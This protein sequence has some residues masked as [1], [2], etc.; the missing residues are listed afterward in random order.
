MAWAMT[1][2]APPGIAAS[3]RS[4]RTRSARASAHGQWQ[5]EPEGRAALGTRLG[6]DAPAVG[7]DDAPADRQPDAAALVAILAVQAVERPEDPLCL[8]RCDPD[9]LVLDRHAHPVLALRLGAHAHDR[10]HAVAE[11]HRVA[12][13]VL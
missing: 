3:R 7:L 8:L 11:L 12:D 5:R 10:R 4:W 13:Q 6:P 9:P 1:C 2:R